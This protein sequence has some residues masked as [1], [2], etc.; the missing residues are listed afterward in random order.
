MTVPILVT[1]KYPLSY[2]KKQVNNS[3]LHPTAIETMAIS[4]SPSFSDSQVPGSWSNVG[5][6]HKYSPQHNSHHVNICGRIT[7]LLRRAVNFEPTFFLLLLQALRDYFF[8]LNNSPPA[9]PAGETIERPLPAHVRVPGKVLLIQ[10]DCAHNVT[11]S[12]GAFRRNCECPS[13][14]VSSFLFL[15]HRC[16]SN[17]CSVAYLQAAQTFPYTTF[18]EKPISLRCKL[19]KV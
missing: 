7:M 15:S 8:V 17:L 12:R 14:F 19:S 16:R 6:H 9:T 2:K 3:D 5:W 4:S 1:F 11:T 18:Q 13:C 10:S